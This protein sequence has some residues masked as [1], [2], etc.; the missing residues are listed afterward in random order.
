MT[1]PTWQR[2]RPDDPNDEHTGWTFASPDDPPFSSPTGWHLASSRT[3]ADPAQVVAFG[4]RSCTALG[5][6]MCQ[7]VPESVWFL[8]GYGSFPPLRCIPDTVNGAKTIRE[9][10]DKAGDTFGKS[11][12][13]QC[14]VPVMA[15]KRSRLALTPSRSVP[16]LWCSCSGCS[17]SEC[18]ARASWQQC[19][20]ARRPLL[21]PDCS[22]ARASACSSCVPGSGFRF[23]QPKPTWQGSTRCRCCGIR[24]RA[25]L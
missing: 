23:S 17:L 20:H 6:G 13:V 14:W 1:H 21:E 11:L 5:Q 18:L 12:Q 16:S 10:Y 7:N 24:R 15:A 2:T 19:A 9:L 3:G 8:A 4:G 22:R 25:R